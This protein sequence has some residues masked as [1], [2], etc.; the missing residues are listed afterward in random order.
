MV[1]G[2]ITLPA[3]RVTAMGFIL[4]GI[5]K[6]KP[7]CLSKGP[8]GEVTWTLVAYTRAVA[9]NLFGNLIKAVGLL[10]TSLVLQEHL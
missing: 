8:N 5:S 9:L 7:A 4:G 1:G 2:P 6:A 3:T 10:C